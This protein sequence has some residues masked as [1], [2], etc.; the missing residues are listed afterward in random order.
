MRRAA[1]VA[2][3]GTAAAAAIFV[4]P[5]NDPRPPESIPGERVVKRINVVRA[6][7]NLPALRHSPSLSRASKRW[8]E[9]LNRLGHLQHAV[10]FLG[11][12]RRAGEVLT[13][14]PNPVKS[15]M[16]S[17]P[18]RAIILGDWTLVGA[19]NVGSTWTAR[20]ATAFPSR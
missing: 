15:W 17:P 4:A 5:R 1:V 6:R 2:V 19:G 16:G 11:P 13:S 9:H 12:Y 14:Y 20:F 18:H 7:H 3:I 8:S 10:G